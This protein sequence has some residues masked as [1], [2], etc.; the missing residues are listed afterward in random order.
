MASNSSA[1]LSRKAMKVVC[2]VMLVSLFA[3]QLLLMPM[4]AVAAR[5]AVDG[6]QNL[7]ATPAAL[8]PNLHDQNEDSDISCKKCSGRDCSKTQCR[9]Q[10]GCPP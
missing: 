6:N 5:V 2:C 8:V 1:V 3:A 10:C 9:G 4:P 7:A